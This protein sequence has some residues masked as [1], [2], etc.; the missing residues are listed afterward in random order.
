MHSKYSPNIF[1][2]LIIFAPE[3]ITNQAAVLY[4]SVH[5]SMHTIHPCIYAYHSSMHTINLCIYA[6]HKSMHLCFSLKGEEIFVR[7][8]FLLRNSSLS[9]YFYLF[10]CRF[11]YNLNRNHMFNNANLLEQNDNSQTI[12]CTY[13]CG[14]N[15]QANIAM[16]ALKTG[17]KF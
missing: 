1:P 6:Y 8:C 7:Y 4:V 14:R 2:V 12:I 10:F 16:S 17:S 9:S 13:K 15:F 3:S 11:F 5:A